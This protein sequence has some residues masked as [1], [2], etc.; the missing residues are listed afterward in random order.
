[1][2]VWA[3][4]VRQV[5]GSRLLLVS[6][7]L[8]GAAARQRTE[9]EFVAAGGDRDRLELRGT[10]PWGM[11]LAAYNTIDLALDPFPYSGGLTTCEALWMGVPVVTCPGETFAGR[12]SLSH[13]SNVGLTETVAGDAHEYVA[14]CRSACRRSSPHLLPRSA[15]KA[16]RMRPIA[17][18]RT[19]ARF[20]GHL[21]ATLARG[22]AAMVRLKVMSARGRTFTTRQTVRCA[23]SK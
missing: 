11:V 3:A 1:M 4:I 18:L 6:P 15:A 10:S 16:L 7:A 23:P 13:L 21:G 14:A 22:L 2:A 19:G 8:D 9:A 17:T 20:A 5:P 12:H